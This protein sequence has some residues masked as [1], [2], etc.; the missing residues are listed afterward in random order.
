MKRNRLY[1]IGEPVAMV[2]M[3]QKGYADQTIARMAAIGATAVREWMH[4]PVVLRDPDTVK[5]EALAAF[6]RVLNRYRELD[7]EITGMNHE[8]FLAGDPVRTSHNEMY[9]RDLTEGSLYMQTMSLMERAWY[10]MARAFPQ[11]EQWEVGN[12][13]NL[14]T[15]LHPIGWQYGTPGFTEE[16]KMDI[17]VDLMYF[18]ARGIRRGNPKAKVVSFSPAVTQPNLGSSSALFCPPAYGMVLA[19][20]RVYERIKSGRFWSSNTDDYFDMIAIHPYMLTQIMPMAASEAYPAERRFFR[21]ESPDAAWRAPV[22]MVYTLM[23]MNGDGNK[24]MLLTEMGFSDWGIPGLDEKQADMQAQMFSLVRETMPYVKTIHSFRIYCPDQEN[25]EAGFIPQGEHYFG[26]FE[27][28][29][30]GKYH[31]RKKA[32]ALQKIYGGTG[33]LK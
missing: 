12:E 26:M 3:T 1:G 25:Y 8:F 17:A 19:V 5:P 29:D 33:E 32:Y 6:T 9:A 2:E 23:S 24:K 28:G 21:A 30:D 10:T 13:W 11:V 7:M 16:E 27:K 31:P 18:S 4:L 14:D 15:F 20:A 22:E